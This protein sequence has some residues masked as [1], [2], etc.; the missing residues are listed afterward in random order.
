MQKH[1]NAAV[2]FVMSIRWYITS[3][4]F[5]KALPSPLILTLG[6]REFI[7]HG[8]FWRTFLLEFPLVLLVG[9]V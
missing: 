8:V 7:S 9:C 6:G 3:Q 1:L 4:C 5:W 2:E